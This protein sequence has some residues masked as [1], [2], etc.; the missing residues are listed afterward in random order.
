MG[1]DCEIQLLQVDTLGL[2]IVREDLRIIAG[3]EQDALAAI[4]DQRGKPP[5]FLHRR[6]LAEGVV[7]NRDLPRARLRGARRSPKRGGR[8]HH[9]RKHNK[10]RSTHRIAPGGGVRPRACKGVAWMWKAPKEKGW[11]KE[12]TPPMACS[13]L[14]R[15]GSPCPAAR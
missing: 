5:I 8:T 1:D 11:Q 12:K 3:I 4:L 14:R 15:D 10:D 7:K 2:D 6:G 13:P 9:R